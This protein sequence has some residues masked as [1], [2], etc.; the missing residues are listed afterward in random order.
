MNVANISVCF[1]PTLMRPMEET[2]ASIIEIK[3]CNVVVEILINYHEKV[4]NS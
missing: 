3:F 2:L 1:G 4:R